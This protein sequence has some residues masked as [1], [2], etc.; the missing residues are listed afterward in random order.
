MQSDSAAFLTESCPHHSNEISWPPT[1]W[2]RKSNSRVV[3]NIFNFL[4]WG[5]E[6]LMSAQITE[7][8]SPLPKKR[9]RASHPICETAGRNAYHVVPSLCRLLRS[10]SPQLLYFHPAYRIASVRAGCRQV[11]DVSGDC[12]GER[13]QA[14]E[15]PI[16]RLDCTRYRIAHHPASQFLGSSN[17]ARS[18]RNFNADISEVGRAAASSLKQPR[19]CTIPPALFSKQ[20]SKR[21]YHS[22]PV[23]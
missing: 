20:P 5:F 18:T 12:S 9:H 8:C 6:R 7:N 23:R 16:S 19:G 13:L 2:S 15:R 21:P 22:K 4:R 3:P 10:R 14:V 11:I 1:L 17:V